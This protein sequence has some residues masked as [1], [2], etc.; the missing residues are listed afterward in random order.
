MS[1]KTLIR[2]ESVAYTPVLMEKTYT[3]TDEQ[4]KQITETKLPE[5]ITWLSSSAKAS[6][7]QGTVTGLLQ[8]TATITL[9]YKYSFSDGT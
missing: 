3:Y 8:G 7:N 1:P 4:G 6:V 2:V 5:S 9:K